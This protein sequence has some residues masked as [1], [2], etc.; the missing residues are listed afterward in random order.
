M[1]LINNTYK[2]LYIYLNNKQIADCLLF[3]QQIESNDDIKV[4]TEENAWKNYVNEQIGNDTWLNDNIKNNLALSENTVYADVGYLTQYNFR[5]A[6]NDETDQYLDS[7]LASEDDRI[8]ITAMS[9]DKYR[10]NKNDFINL[11]QQYKLDKPLYLNII[12]S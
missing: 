1:K 12:K 4:F 11:V 2:I 3:G 5:L 6:V 7:L 9:G 10:L 8:Q